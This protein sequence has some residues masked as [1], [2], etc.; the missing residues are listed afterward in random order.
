MKKINKKVIGKMK[1]E[2][3]DVPRVGLKP[4]MYSFTKEDDEEEKKT[5]GI[6]KKVF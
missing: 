4:K 6:N 5:K 2:A 3:K 1:D